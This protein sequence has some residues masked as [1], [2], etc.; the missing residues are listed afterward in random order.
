[1]SPAIRTGRLRRETTETTVEAA[2]NLDGA[3][4]AAVR[5]GIGMLDHLIEQIAR[6]SRID[7]A[8]DVPAS[9]LDRDAHHLVE[10][11]AITLGQALSGALGDRAG[12]VR[13]ADA[14]VPMDE[15][16]ALV[17]LD[18]SGRPFVAFDVH[19]DGERIG[20]LPTE[21]IEHFLWSLAVN[22]GLT[23]HVRLLAGRNDHHRAEAIVKALARALGA[24]VRVDPR[25]AG[26]VPSTKGVIGSGSAASS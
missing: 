19:F 26:A 25:L 17:A 13:M 14:T 22:A 24:A 5:T 11:V 18:I 6:H 23:L 21:M 16:L 8:I 2:V 10:D 15:A 20:A 9:D 12:I 7:I 3:G 1:M 4:T